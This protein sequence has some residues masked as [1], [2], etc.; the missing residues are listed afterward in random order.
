MW[1]KRALSATIG[2]LRGGEKAEAREGKQLN[3][4]R[5]DRAGSKTPASAAASLA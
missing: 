3:Y 4:C 1:P 2:G 5:V